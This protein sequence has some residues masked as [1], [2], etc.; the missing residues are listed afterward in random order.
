M[1]CSIAAATT[2][3]VAVSGAPHG[4]F[5]A[6]DQALTRVGW[7]V[8]EMPSSAR[9]GGGTTTI[10]TMYGS[11]ASEWIQTAMEGG[12]NGSGSISVVGNG[13]NVGQQ[14]PKQPY[15]I[16]PVPYD[17]P[18]RVGYGGRRERMYAYAGI[19]ALEAKFESGGNGGARGGGGDGSDG[20]LTLTVRTYLAG[21]VDEAKVT[22]S[23]WG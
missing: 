4:L 11:A 22:F 19:E 18:V 3:G 21:L 1:C 7:E 23:P 12:G 5:F 16:H 6:P 17:G 13:N 2:D 8:R 15:H 20:M 14:P 10:W 9:G